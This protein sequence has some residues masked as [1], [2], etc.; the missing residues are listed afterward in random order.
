MMVW[1]LIGCVEQGFAEISLDAIAVVNGDFD[2]VAQPMLALG[3][4]NAPF[5]GYIDHATWDPSDSPPERDEAGN[6]VEG[7]LTAAD[8]QG[9]KEIDKYNAVF[10]NSGTRGLNA[11]VYNYTLE[12]D[13]QILADEYSIDNVCGFVTHGG[14]LVVSDWAYDLVETC[15]PDRLEWVGDDATI[16]AAQLGRAGEVLADIKDKDLQGVLGTSVAIE[17]N[18]TAWAVMESVDKDVEVL[19]SG[20]VEYQPSDTEDYATLEKSPLM[21][22]WKEGNGQVVVTTFHWIVQNGA[23]AQNLLLYGVAGMKVGSGSQ[24]DEVSGG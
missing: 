24:S 20:T 9:K 11:V 17:Y 7:L 13:N 6:S 4:G 10:V 22:R 15:F 5:N 14:T 19:V 23:V 12:A 3:I 21:V 2:N 16:D 18:Y 1:A 8:A